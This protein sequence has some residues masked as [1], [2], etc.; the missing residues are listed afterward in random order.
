M[1][2]EFAIKVDNLSKCYH[3]YDRPQDRLKQTFV[4]R[5][6]RLLSRPVTQYQ[7]E[8]WALNDVSF[9][10]K[11]GESVGILGRNGSGKSTLL[12]LICG[13][14]TPTSGSVEVNG[15]VAALLELGS[16]FNPEFTG[17]ENVYLNGSLLGLSREQIDNRF[18]EIASFADIG[19]FIDQ[20][21]KTYSSGMLVRLAFAVQVQLEPDILIVDEA[22]AV[23][24]ALFQKRCFQ[25]I[26]KLVSDGVTLLFVSHDIE[27]IRTLTHKSLL[28]KEG[29][30]V[31][32]GVSS[33]VVLAYR[34]QLHA[35]EAAYFSSITAQVA[36]RAATQD[37]T[38]RAPAAEASA[39]ME[40]D[41]AVAVESTQP[42]TARS[43]KLEFGSGEVEVVSVETRD[44]S[45]ERVHVFYPNEPL[46]VRV[47]CRAKKDMTHLNVG[48]RIR[49]KEG[50]KLYSWGTL[51]QD[52]AN[53]AAKNGESLF[54]NR[55]VTAGE[56]FE[57]IFKAPCSLGVNLYEIQAAV[58]YEGTPD[59]HNQR[60]LHWRDEAAF[61]Q[62]LI[63]R[64]EYFFGGVLDMRMEAQ[65]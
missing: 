16:G 40:S 45:G 49:N 59:Y 65:W 38:P 30:R 43:D 50:V 20:S 63:K 34:K 7:R 25:R 26:E 24:D 61:F 11:R 21:V 39:E 13:T 48:M 60:M 19:A 35:E 10:V 41:V 42:V 5:V 32:Y 37:E 44:A 58:S 31:A 2:S 55:E 4:P 14:L 27:S 23:G 29:R 51:N 46:T 53:I 28:L 6:Q 9:D 62:V 1:S 52:M 33:D 64:E 36:E 8:F 22:L 57:V 54:W 17:R 15:R 18:D 3:I 12:Q 56:E 47:V